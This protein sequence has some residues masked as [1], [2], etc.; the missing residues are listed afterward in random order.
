MLL[1]FLVQPLLILVQEAA[2]RLLL[3]AALR[4]SSS[5]VG[6]VLRVASTWALVLASAEF[7]FWGPFEACDIDTRGLKEAM[8]LFEGMS[9]V[10]GLRHFSIA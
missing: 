6:Y 5:W 9:S 8:G 2:H 1:F 4:G 7:L 10:L 3:P